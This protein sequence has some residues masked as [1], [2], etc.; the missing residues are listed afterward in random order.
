MKVSIEICI[1]NQ[2]EAKYFLSWHFTIFVTA[3]IIFLSA[4]VSTSTSSSVLASFFQNLIPLEFH[5]CSCFSNSCQLT[6]IQRTTITTLTSQNKS[7]KSTVLLKMLDVEEIQTSLLRNLMFFF[8]WY[9][10]IY[11][12]FFPFFFWNFTDNLQHTLLKATVLIRCL[13][14]THSQLGEYLDGWLLGE[15]LML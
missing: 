11:F 3:L 5:L 12:A 7:L 10:R 8:Y 2:G 1:W 4:T 6:A 15:T 13:K 9:S 14:L